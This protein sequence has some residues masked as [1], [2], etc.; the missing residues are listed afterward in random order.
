MKRR[1]SRMARLAALAL[2]VGLLGPAPADGQAKAPLTKAELVQALSTRAYSS[3][4]LA[5][6]IRTNCLNFEPTSRDVTDLSSLGATDE[7][8]AEIAAC[9]ADPLVVTLAPSR[10]TVAAGGTGW[11][12]VRARQG[13]EPVPGL[14]LQLTGAPTV[15]GNSL[16]ATTDER[17]RAT[18]S[19]PAGPTVRSFRMPLRAVGRQLSGAP[20]L[21]V[22]VVSG[23]PAAARLSPSHLFIDPSLDT[24]VNIHAAITDGFGNAVAGQSVV[25]TDR[26]GPVEF[27]A[28]VTDEEGNAELQARTG[29]LPNPGAVALRVGGRVLGELTTEPRL[30]A[31]DEPTEASS[32]DAPGDPLETGESRQPGV[33]GEAAGERGSD[34]AVGA[35]AAG[36]TEPGDRKRLARPPENIELRLELAR[37]L[38]RAGRL[39][40]AEREYIAVVRTASGGLQVRASR[41][42]ALLRTRPFHFEVAAFAGD[43]L[44][45]AAVSVRP[46]RRVRFWAR[47]DRSLGLDPLPLD[48]GPG[49]IGGVFGGAEAQWGT[50]RLLATRVEVGRRRFDDVPLGRPADAADPNAAGPADLAQNVVRVEQSLLIPTGVSIGSLTVGGYVG[51]WFDR[52]DWLVYARGEIP[53]ESGFSVGPSLYVGQTVGRISTNAGRVPEREVR[54]VLPLTYRTLTGW[55]VEPGVALGRVT[56]DVDGFS[57]TLYEG[58]LLIEAPFAGPH[59]LRLF[60]RRQS[61]PGSE[62]FTVVAVGLLLRIE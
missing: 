50:E 34:A 27:A 49:A 31:A 61:A 45:A 47:Y 3:A 18:F 52:D 44:R 56:S 33:E 6:L 12:E 57:G 22:R 39:T 54:A 24:V 2:T 25:L 46:L 13:A 23:S 48:R 8:L 26:A 40:E 30:G 7:V 59:R 20:T 15:A 60:L 43:G 58:R 9:R 55:L 4:E 29:W 10:V 21:T 1:G 53:F 14:R 37:H 17:G 16:V 35:P 32:P 36:G 19:I 62:S 11:V 38:E 5:E 41:A 42:L 51:R 28:G